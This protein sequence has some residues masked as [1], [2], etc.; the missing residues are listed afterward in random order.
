[1]FY[2]TQ[3]LFHKPYSTAVVESTALVEYEPY[4]LGNNPS[5]ALHTTLERVNPVDTVNNSPV[6]PYDKPSVDSYGSNS[7]SSTRIVG[8]GADPID[9][10]DSSYS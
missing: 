1:V 6:V 2:P 7:F 3:L 10:D 9:D 5:E 8:E 4:L